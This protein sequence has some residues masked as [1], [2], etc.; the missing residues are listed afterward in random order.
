MHCV[1]TLTTGAIGYRKQKKRKKASKEEENKRGGGGF[2]FR[3]FSETGQKFMCIIFNQNISSYDGQKEYQV[4][5]FLFR[6]SILLNASNG[7]NLHCSLLLIIPNFTSSLRRW[8]GVLNVCGRMWG[9]FSL[10]DN[11]RKS[12]AA[13]REH[14]MYIVKH[15]M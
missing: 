10:C 13:Y 14:H 9:L 6:T 7:Q 3:I 2:S 11:F 8:P 1:K 4:F 15:Y 12:S 5:T